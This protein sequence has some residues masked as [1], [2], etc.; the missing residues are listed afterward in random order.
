MH[1]NA[2]VII[3]TVWE[4]DDRSKYMRE[5]G[6]SE[7]QSY[8][9]FF[10]E[11]TRLCL[12]PAFFCLQFYVGWTC[13]SMIIC[14]KENCIIQ[15]KPSWLKGKWLLIQLVIYCHCFSLIRIYLFIH[16]V[17]GSLRHWYLFNFFWILQL[18]MLLVVFFLNGG[19]FSGISLLLEQ[20]KST[21]SLQQLI[22]RCFPLYNLWSSFSY[23]LISIQAFV[24]LHWIIYK[25]L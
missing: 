13:I 16:R 1:V 3:R 18:L 12:N 5:I 2:F 24:F 10:L 23:I 7:L 22:L 6:A 8:S 17:R 14:W 15:L 9:V 20:M 19:L 25:N 11:L 21:L 4:K